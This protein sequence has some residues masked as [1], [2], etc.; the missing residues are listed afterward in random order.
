MLLAAVFLSL[1]RPSKKL[2][3]QN[4]KKSAN[5]SVSESLQDEPDDFIE[6]DFGKNEDS[7]RGCDS[8]A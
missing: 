6:A 1:V 7:A 4:K 3:H 2:Q 5:K 8:M